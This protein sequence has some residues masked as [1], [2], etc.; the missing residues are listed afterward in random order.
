VRPSISEQL[1]G[2][3]RIVR[4]VLGPH[5][6][7]A[8]AG[9]IANGMAVTLATIAS[10]WQDVPAFQRWETGEI[11]GLLGD[12]VPHLDA[13]LAEEVAAFSNG[14]PDAGADPLDLRALD[15]RHATARELL[16][17]AVPAIESVDAPAAARGRLHALAR[18]RI[19]R[20]P[21]VA[22]RPRS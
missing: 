16:A 3:A 14:G 10:S 15:A 9:D 8:Y 18:E 17:R 11:V 20:Y 21:L 1:D 2:M 4:D 6:D 22:P 5:L 12:A 7:D 19:G 13:A